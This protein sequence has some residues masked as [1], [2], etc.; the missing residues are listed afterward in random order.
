MKKIILSITILFL[1]ISLY[2]QSLD[3]YIDFSANTR[4]VNFSKFSTI[5]E[6]ITCEYS[7]DGRVVGSYE[8]SSRSTIISL[9][10]S[11]SKCEFRFYFTDG[12]IEARD[13]DIG[14]AV[15][16]DID[17][18]YFENP[19]NFAN[20]FST[21]CSHDKYSYYIINGVLLKSECVCAFYNSVS[22][23]VLLNMFINQTL[24]RYLIE[25]CSKAGIIATEPTSERRMIN[26]ELLNEMTQNNSISNIQI[27]DLNGKNIAS[28]KANAITDLSTG[29]YLINYIENGVQ[30]F[31]KYIKE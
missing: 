6:D 12:G 2:S 9:P 27:I 17:I 7:I 14:I 30:K 10:S 16:D 5:R 24:G 21:T 23:A 26:P 28:N 22:P 29:I 15:V 18:K 4:E 13:G 11:F 8:V 1:T 20:Y 31:G 3:R 25:A 19:D